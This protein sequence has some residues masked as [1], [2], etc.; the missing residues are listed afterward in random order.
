[1]RGKQLDNRKVGPRTTPSRSLRDSHLPLGQ[2]KVHQAVRPRRPCVEQVADRRAGELDGAGQ[3]GDIHR[4]GQQHSPL[5][6]RHELFVSNACSARCLCPARGSRE[7]SKA[8]WLGLRGL[9]SNR[10]GRKGS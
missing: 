3:A 9:G 8:R 2:V 4:T 10:L 6:D 5:T 1:M 7:L